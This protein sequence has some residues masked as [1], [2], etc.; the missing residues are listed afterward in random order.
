MKVGFVPINVKLPKIIIDT[1]SDVSLIDKKYYNET[2]AHC[3]SNLL[4][5]LSVKL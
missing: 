5:M 4:H 1:S 3:E 2:G